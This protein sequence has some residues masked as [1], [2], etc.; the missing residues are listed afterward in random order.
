MKHVE[1]SRLVK[2]GM[3]EGFD[4]SRQSHIID[5]EKV[6][7]HLEEVTA[8]GGAMVDT[9]AMVDYFPERWFDLVVVLQ[10]DNAILYDRLSKRGY[11]EAKV[12]ENVEC[13]IMHVLAEE[14]RCR[15][16]VG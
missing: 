2:E 11:S 15:W 16:N 9:H 10:T 3:S 6:C 14:G 7:D 5:E 1:V 13:E 12:K 8:Q 4:E